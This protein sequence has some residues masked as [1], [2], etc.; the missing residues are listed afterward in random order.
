MVAMT[1]LGRVFLLAT[2]VG[3]AGCSSSL[4]NTTPA[5]GCALIANENAYVDHR[6]GS[7]DDAHGGG[8]GACAYRTLSY[9]L[10]N[11][12]DNINIELAAGD[13]YQGGVA[14]ET[15][16]FRLTGLQILRCNGAT[17]E[18]AADQG[19]YDGIVQ[20]SGDSNGV[21]TCRFEGLA[22]GGYCLNV[23]STGPDGV[24]P[25][26]VL[27][28]TFSNCANVAISIGA[29]FG[30]V[31]ISNS[32]F[33]MNYVSIYPT[34]THAGISIVDNTF[35]GVGGG[36]DVVCDDAEPGITGSG[37][38]RDGATIMCGVCGGCPFGP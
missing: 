2:M 30:G 19:T 18:N 25:H 22:W 4:G 21:D 14:G 3:L 15:L 20:F 10:A 26:Q 17:L 13:T 9:A 11:A 27:A 6:L 28:T 37:N 34:G 7:D 8:P 35:A 23:N 29:G 5:G 12:T 24:F 31:S 36:D 16:P 32:T 38:V 1:P 33:T